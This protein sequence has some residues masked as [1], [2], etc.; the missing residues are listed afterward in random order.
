MLHGADGDGLARDVQAALGQAVPVD[1]WEMLTDELCGLAAD[2]E[3]D[4]VL[5]LLGD[6]GGDG[7]GNDVARCKF[8]ATV[9]MR[10]KPFARLVG[11]DAAFAAYGFGNQEGAAVFRRPIKSKNR[12]ESA[13]SFGNKCSTHLS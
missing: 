12:L 8:G 4:E 9:V 3:R 6:F 1:G 5:R 10:H 2:V 11:Q 7:S 13:S